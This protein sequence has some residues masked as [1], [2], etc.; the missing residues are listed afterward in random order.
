MREKDKCGPYG[1]SNS[2]L[3]NE[4]CA[5]ESNIQET[6]TDVHLELLVSQ[7]AVG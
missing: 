3:R 7:R 6:K 2:L 4:N 5:M 1:G